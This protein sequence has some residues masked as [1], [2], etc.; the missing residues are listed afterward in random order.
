MSA[1]FEELGKPGSRT[2]FEPLS[3]SDET[4]VVSRYVPEADVV[5]TSYQSEAELEAA[6]IKQ[7][8][9]QAYERLTITC[10]ED[11]SANL[12]LQLERLNRFQFTDAEWKRFFAESI[13]SANDGIVEK[14]RRIQEDHIQA[15]KREDGS[16]KNVYL[17]DKEHI[18]NNHLQVIN[19]YETD[20]ASG[21]ARSTRYDVT[22]LVNGLPMVHIEL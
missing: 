10:E 9:G 11:L 5:A 2:R 17:L 19:Q 16:T 18:H 22:I 7:L 13:A 6:L 14:T 1:V 12:R 21:A 20:E 3:V 4:T 8:A 15:I